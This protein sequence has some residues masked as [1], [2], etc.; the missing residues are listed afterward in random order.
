MATGTLKSLGYANTH[1]LGS[2]SRAK[3]ILV[4]TK[5]L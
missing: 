1:N 4:R 5:H 3:D 2:Y